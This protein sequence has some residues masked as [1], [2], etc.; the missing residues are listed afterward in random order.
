MWRRSHKYAGQPVQL[1]ATPGLLDGF[2]AFPG[3]LPKGP[4]TIADEATTGLLGVPRSVDAQE[5]LQGGL[6]HA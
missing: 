6:G 5:G 2:A 4:W 1:I 3:D